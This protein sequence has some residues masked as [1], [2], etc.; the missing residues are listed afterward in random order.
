[1]IIKNLF[2]W[3][4]SLCFFDVRRKTG[5]KNYVFSWLRKKISDSFFQQYIFAWFL[6]AKKNRGFSNLMLKITSTFLGGYRTNV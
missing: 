3:F 2:I 6:H 4:Q 5:P 1:M